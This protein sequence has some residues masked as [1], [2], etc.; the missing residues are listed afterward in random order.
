MQKFLE[1]EREL[2]VYSWG[3]VPFLAGSVPD[4]G[5]D[6]LVLDNHGA[7]LELDSDGGLGVQAKLVAREPGQ[8]LRLPDGRVPNQH[9]LEHVV[10]F[11]VRVIRHFLQTESTAKFRDQRAHSVCMCV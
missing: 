2:R 4:L 11:L 8:Y 9:H 7:G 5:L 3:V 6:T 10:D 1:R